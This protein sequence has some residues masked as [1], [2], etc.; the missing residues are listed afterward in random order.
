MP[1]KV[2]LDR[3]RK[4]VSRSGRPV[5]TFSA[6]NI[7]VRKG[8]DR[9]HILHGATQI[10][11]VL[12]IVFNR[13][14]AKVGPQGLEN[15]LDTYL[16]LLCGIKFQAVVGLEQKAAKV[17][18][19]AFSRRENLVVG[20]AIEN[21][22]IE[23]ARESIHT[24]KVKLDRYCIDD[25]RSFEKIKSTALS[26]IKDSLKNKA[27]GKVAR[28]RVWI[29][30]LLEQAVEGV[31]NICTLV[32]IFSNFE[33]SCTLDIVHNGTTKEQNIWGLTMA[34]KLHQA[35]GDH[36]DKAICKVLLGI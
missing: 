12:I 20:G 29:L 13:I 3:N 23:K 35:I 14:L 8:E 16:H 21:Q 1:F 30:E 17:I 2:T 5:F 31:S 10:S 18:T 4:Q 15:T 28:Y 24:I 33:F 7:A 6:K 32:E 19:I 26:L 11:D 9:R 25:L 27:N 22:G 34:N 36:D